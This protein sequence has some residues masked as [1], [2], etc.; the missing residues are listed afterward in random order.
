MSNQPSI[1][2]VPDQS[3]LV[4]ALVSAV[5][6]DV[7]MACDHI[8]T[9]LD[10]YSYTTTTCRLSRFLEELTGTPFAGLP[11][12]EEVWE[13]MNAGDK[14]REGWERNDALALQ[15]ISDMVATRAEQATSER[16]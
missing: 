10:R 11:F 2:L 14:L 4:I 5:G 13:A 9:E 1:P 15:A 8:A 3:E 6:T 16:S 12:D 7:A